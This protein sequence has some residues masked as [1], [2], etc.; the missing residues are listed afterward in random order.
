[1]VPG[2]DAGPTCIISAQYILAL[3]EV[4]DLSRLLGR[5]SEAMELRAE[6]AALRTK[7]HARFWSESEGLYFDRPCGPEIS[8]YGNAWTIV[9]GAAGP[10]E[11]ARIMQRFPSDPKLAPGSFF[12]WHAGFRALDIAGAYDR[13]PEFLGPWR[14]MIDYG[15]S[16]F[17]EENSYWRSL[18]H[19]WSAHPALEFLTRV[20]GVT[21]RAPGFAEI[22]VAPHR[23]GLGHA[24]GNVCTPRGNISVAWKVEGAR[25]RIE[26]DAP[27][28]TPVHVKFPNGE[29]QQ[30][31]GGKFSAEVSLS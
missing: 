14:E 8:Q 16:T 25:F 21:P 10:R 17:V 22:D 27:A 30:F 28:A 2:A 20:L 12:W 7:L 3:D 4:A 11:C 29:L 5:E 9:C 31:D 1:V 18:C 13:M 26:I 19:A 15:L 24:R 23:C 6:A